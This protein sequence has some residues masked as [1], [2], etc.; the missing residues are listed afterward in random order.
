MRPLCLSKTRN[1]LSAQELYFFFEFRPS[2]LIS[3]A[4]P[5]VTLRSILRSR[6]DL[7]LENFALRHQIG[8]LRRSVNKVRN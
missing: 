6:L 7:Q 1:D 3:L 2:M 8:V 4:A 5:L